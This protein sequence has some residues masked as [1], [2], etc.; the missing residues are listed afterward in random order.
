MKKI[1]EEKKILEMKM[2]EAI[3]YKDTNQIPAFTL[4]KTGQKFYLTTLEQ[5][6]RFGLNISKN[7]NVK[8]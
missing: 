4:N 2:K 1:N 8:K 5:L 6:K 3:K 7:K